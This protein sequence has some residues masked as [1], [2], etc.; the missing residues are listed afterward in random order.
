[1]SSCPG[2]TL[3][4]YLAWNLNITVVELGETNFSVGLAEALGTIPRRPHL[5]KEQFSQLVEPFE[6]YRETVENRLLDYDEDQDGSWRMY[7]EFVGS[8]IPDHLITTAQSL[9]KQM[10]EENAN[11]HRRNS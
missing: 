3:E 4:E 9:I 11:N 6:P 7:A 2:T 8:D 1:M 10:A 5:T